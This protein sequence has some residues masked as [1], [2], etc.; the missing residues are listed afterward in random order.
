MNESILRVALYKCY[1]CI[2]YMLNLTLLQVPRPRVQVLHRLSVISSPRLVRYVG[3][4]H[5]LEVTPWHMHIKAGVPE[6][7]LTAE[8]TWVV[9]IPHTSP[10]LVWS[11]QKQFS[12]LCSAITTVCDA[13]TSA[14][15]KPQ[16]SGVRMLSPAWK[17]YTYAVQHL[18][19]QLLTLKAWC[20]TYCMGY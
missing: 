18:C 13:A 6:A 4:I 19:S 16:P 5:V 1:P 20:Q 17:T 10:S 14:K 3:L 7:L 8:L 12:A 11:I 9:S 2:T 15:H